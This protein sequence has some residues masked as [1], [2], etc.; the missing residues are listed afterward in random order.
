MISDSKK[1]QMK[2]A[3]IIGIIIGFFMFMLF[4]SVTESL[5]SLAI[6]PVVGIV[7]AA[8]AYLAPDYDQKE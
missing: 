5:V 2:N 8:Q 1:R 6:I 4:Y 3:S 7:G